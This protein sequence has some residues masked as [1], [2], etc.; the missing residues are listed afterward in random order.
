MLA[1][2]GVPIL[3]LLTLYGIVWPQRVVWPYRAWNKLARIYAH[4]AEYVVLRLCYW[5]V[6][7]AG[8][9]T[10]TQCRLAR[11]GVEESMWVSRQSL[12]PSRYKQ[13]HSGP[14][15]ESGERNWI[16]RYITWAWWSHQLWLLALLP[17]LCILLWLEEEEEVVV[18]ESIYTLF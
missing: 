4:A 9:W 7:V 15:G 17:F 2:S 3:V 5:T 16:L 14:G 6:I 12:Q 18:Q 11:P 13:L 10:G 1:L 8:G